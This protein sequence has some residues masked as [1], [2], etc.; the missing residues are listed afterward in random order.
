MCQTL[1]IVSLESHSRVFCDLWS[2]ILLLKF[3]GIGE[4]SYKNLVMYCKV[5]SIYN[6]KISSRH[7]IKILNSKV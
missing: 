2:I 1:K 6:S 5:I 4:I 7:D 3:A